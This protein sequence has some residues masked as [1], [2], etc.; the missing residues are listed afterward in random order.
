MMIIS[1]IGYYA[2]LIASY[3]AITG[4]LGQEFMS[5]F[6][7]FMFDDYAQL[8]RVHFAPMMPGWS[9]PVV[10]LIIIAGLFGMIPGFI[11]IT[12]QIAAFVIALFLARLGFLLIGYPAPAPTITLFTYALFSTGWLFLAVTLG[13]RSLWNWIRDKRDGIA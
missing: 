4:W 12:A 10:V 7:S 2:F 3:Y 11:R 9:H 1:R 6:W 8:W 5:N 13:D